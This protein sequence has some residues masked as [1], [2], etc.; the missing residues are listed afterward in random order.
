MPFVSIDIWTIIM[1][2]GNLLILFLL[3]K[4]FLFKPVMEIL[5]ERDKEIHDMYADAEETK[6]SA[7]R[8]KIEYSQKLSTARGKAD[9]IVNDAVLKARQASDEIIKDAHE[10]AD[11]MLVKAN[12]KI[13]TEHKKAINNAKNDI[14][15]IA[16][17]IA[18][19]I[20][21]KD[22]TPSDHTKMI[23]KF[24]ENLGDAS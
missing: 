14:S 23:E 10:Q 6:N 2:W 18:E 15:D 3:M 22:I 19:K 9:S 7:E 5:D 11:I 4:K 20:I 24:I 16:L 12:E 8:L 1:Q 17:S 21:E 13:R